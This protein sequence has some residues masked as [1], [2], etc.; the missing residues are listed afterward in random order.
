ME[1]GVL[2]SGNGTAAARPAGRKAAGKAALAGPLVIVVLIPCARAQNVSDPT[3]LFGSRG[4]IGTPSARMAPDGVEGL[5][6]KGATD[7]TPIVM[8]S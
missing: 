3:N 7:N 6:V 5:A 1:G 8:G 4:L 2:S